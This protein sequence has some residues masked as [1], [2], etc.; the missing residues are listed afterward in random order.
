VSVSG[1]GQTNLEYLIAFGSDPQ[2]V[3]LTTSGMATAADFHRMT[4]ELLGDE[5]F[6]VPMNVL[7]DHTDLAAAQ[8]TNDEV[9]EAAESVTQLG[10][11]LG[12]SR[13][14]ILAPHAA[15]F[16]VSRAALALADTPRLNAKVFG[17]RENALR[18]LQRK[19]Y[20]VE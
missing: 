13:V 14:A 19:P 17:V 7:L 4:D 3:T 8:M 15:T 5:R 20:L 10:P 9:Q 16:G 6:R 1:Q 12:S 11:Q 18:W 2:D